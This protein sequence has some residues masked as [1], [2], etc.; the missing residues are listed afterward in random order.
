LLAVSG[1]NTAAAW[2]LASD[3][4]VMAMGGFGGSDPAPTLAQFKAM[5]A[6]GE[7]HYVLVSGGSGGGPGGPGGRSGTVS[8]ILSWVEAHGTVVSSSAWGGSSSAGTLYVVSAS[9]AR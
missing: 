9:A 7:V 6:A 5:V 4:A 3:R 2:I 1:S 8:S